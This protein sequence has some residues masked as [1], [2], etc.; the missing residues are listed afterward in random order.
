MPRLACQAKLR[1][2]ET[3][4]EPGEVVI[5]PMAEPACDFAQW[6]GKPVDVEAVKAI[7]RPYRILLPDS[8]VTMDYSAERINVVTD[9]DGI[10]TEVRCG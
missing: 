8:M 7:G 10:V 2:A 6:V 4:D 1:A 9:K 3:L 5:P